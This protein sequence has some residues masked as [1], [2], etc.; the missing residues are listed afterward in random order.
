[1]INT[2]LIFLSECWFAVINAGIVFGTVVDLGVEPSIDMAKEEEEDD[3]EDDDEDDEKEVEQEEREVEEKSLQRLSVENDDEEVECFGASKCMLWRESESRCL[4]VIL[5]L[6][7]L[8]QISFWSESTSW[9]WLEW[10]MCSSPSLPRS[11]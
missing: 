11:Q 7:F 9:P 1:M 3:D 6:R 2:G 10:D 4:S 5:I 8:R